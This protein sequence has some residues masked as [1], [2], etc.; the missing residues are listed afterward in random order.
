MVTIKIY[1]LSNPIDNSIFYVGRTI[2]LNVRL[3]GHINQ[4]CYKSKKND[5]I[6]KILKSGLKPIIEELD[7]IECK[8][9]GDDMGDGSSAGIYKDFEIEHYTEQ[10]VKD[11][12]IP[13]SAIVFENEDYDDNGTNI[14]A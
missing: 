9:L 7:S 3:S 5:L 14:T 2:N 4:L 10:E 8:N 11:G 1:T 12:A 6:T 13:F